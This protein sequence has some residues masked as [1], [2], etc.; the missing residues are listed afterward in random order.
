VKQYAR[1]RIRNLFVRVLG[2]I[3]V[4][5][6][7]SLGSQVLLLYGARGLLP[8]CAV[9]GHVTVTVFR[10]HCSD[11]VLWWGTV[12]G[13]ALGAMLALGFV[14]RWALLASWLLYASYVTIGRD[15]LSFQW[16]N[17]LLESGFFALFVTPGGW[18][19]RDGGPPHP[20]GVFLMQWLLFRLY[21][22]SGLAKLL[23]GDPTWR[24]LTAMVTYWETAP[25]PTWLGWYAHQLPLGAQRLFAALT[26]AV[27]LGVPALMWGPR[28]LR[29]AVFAAMVAFQ[30]VVLTTANYGFFNYLSLALCLWV[31]DD[32]HLGWATGDAGPAPAATTAALALATAVLV[33]VSLVPFLPLVPSLRPL[34]RALL[35]LRAVLDQVRSINA[36]HLFAQMTLVRREAVIE[37]SD[38]GVDWRAYELHYEPGD[39]DRAPPF[40]APHQPRVDFQMWFLLLGGRG[41][42]PWFQVLLERIQHDPSVVAPLFARNPFPD[43]PPRLL[44]V[45]VY[46]YRFTDGATRARS[47][48]WWARE[49]LGASGPIVTDASAPSS[50]SSEHPYRTRLEV[51]DRTLHDQS[52]MPHQIGDHR[53]AGD[54]RL[55]LPVHVLLD[56]RSQVGLRALEARGD[57]LEER[58]DLPG[59]G[60]AR[61]RG[62]DGAAAGVPEDD[63]G[64]RPEDERTVLETREPLGGH[65]VSRHADHEEIA[66]PL[67]EHDLRGH[68]RVGAAEDRRERRLLGRHGRPPDPVA[69]RRE[70]VALNEATIAVE[71]L[72]QRGRGGAGDGI[73]LRPCRGE[74]RGQARCA[75]GDRRGEESPAAPGISGR[76]I[77]DASSL[78]DRLTRARGRLDGRPRAPRVSALFAPPRSRGSP[79]PVAQHEVARR[80][81][82]TAGVVRVAERRQSTAVDHLRTH[83]AH[84]ATLRVGE[85][86]RHR[87]ESRQIVEGAHRRWD[88]HDVAALVRGERRSRRVPLA[89]HRLGAIGTGLL[90]RRHPADQEA[91]V[92]P[93]RILPRGDPAREVVECIGRW[94]EPGRGQ[95][96]AEPFARMHPSSQRGVLAG[97]RALEQAT[98]SARQQDA[99]L[100]EELAD[101]RHP[102]PERL[103]RPV[104]LTRWRPGL[105][106]RQ[107]RIRDLVVARVD[108]APGEGMH[109]GKGHAAMAFEHE[110]GEWL[111]AYRLLA[112]QDDRTRRERLDVRHAGDCSACHGPG[113]RTC[114]TRPAR[115]RMNGERF[116]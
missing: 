1:A 26:L 106:G 103:G 79:A 96:P 76:G 36:Y 59:N 107:H 58:A 45:A 12:A 81:V 13:G 61:Q 22:E 101:G 33:P 25:L 27:E 109:A 83:R 52:V 4:I 46:R 8:A 11:A 78:L 65:Q 23:L 50:R 69:V 34:A 30:L 35:P 41:L 48:A 111:R 62:L 20:L 42:A 70:H 94:R 86:G 18:R 72:L 29:P 6:F 89:A 74:A 92:E 32:R 95:Q 55:R 19:L 77:H 44:R 24:D 56:R 90:P 114:L 17:L 64:S 87:G 3:F 7:W 57:V 99:D 116:A 82:V 105:I 112:Q 66:H 63:Q 102:V 91:G 40:V 53:R 104:A 84:H 98:A 73:V 9:A 80:Q 10:L 21:V 37:G 60:S 75:A 67:I 2:V 85:D 54:H 51:V 97:E 39:V 110:E 68:A 113:P 88:Q 28:R 49:L 93:P 16:D 100:L 43:A 108:D 38:D 31:L 14:P 15:F 47:G 115:P 5:A 71:E